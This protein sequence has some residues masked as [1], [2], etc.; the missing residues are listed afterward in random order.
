M[1]Y[2]QI[3]AAVSAAAVGIALLPAACAQQVGSYY[4]N[5]YTGSFSYGTRLPTPAAGLT[6]NGGRSHDASARPVPKP[7]TTNNTR[8][9]AYRHPP[10][11]SS[12]SRGSS[13]YRCGLDRRYE[14]PTAVPLTLPVP[15]R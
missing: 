7:T 9:S 12:P 2:R 11:P 14:G 13:D 15:A 5:P 6:A 4:R 1:N 3:L 8:T 10:A